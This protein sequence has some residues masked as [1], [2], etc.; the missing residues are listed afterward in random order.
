LKT[1]KELMT[2]AQTAVI[3]TFMNK[4]A[5]CQ[6]LPGLKELEGFYNKRKKEVEISDTDDISIRD[7]LKGRAEALKSE[8][9]AEQF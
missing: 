5:S 6:T 9:E 4:I 1:V 2:E 7:A 3:D 8:D